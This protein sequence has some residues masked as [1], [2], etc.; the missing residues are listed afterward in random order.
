MVKKFGPPII[1]SLIAAF[2]VVFASY[3]GINDRFAPLELV[4]V[5]A[6]ASEINKLASIGSGDI[7]TTTNTKTLTNKTLSGAYYTVCTILMEGVDYTLSATEA[8]CSVLN[9]TGSPSGQGL[10]APT[11]A[12]SG[13]TR[14][15][16]VRNAGGDSGTVTLKKSGGTGVDVA[17]G[18]TA[19]VYWLSSDYVRE[20]ADAT[21]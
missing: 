3:A 21:H 14:Y 7:L 5:T 2:V 16:T 9:V 11:I 6:T 12:T 19:R 1:T 15:Y 13:V 8:L 20:T 10:I 4:D 17:T 18:K